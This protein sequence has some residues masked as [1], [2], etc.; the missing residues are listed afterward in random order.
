M[1]KIN[2]GRVVLGGLVAG[3]VMNAFWVANGLLLMEEW[4]A[5]MERS[6]QPV[7]GEGATALLHVLLPFVGGL[8]AVWFYAAARPRF[9]P[10]PKTAALI[11][12]ANWAVGYLVPGLAWGTTVAF[13]PRLLGIWIVWA[14]PGV[15]VATLAGAWL[16]KEA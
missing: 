16:Y 4:Q 1:G 10:G 2:W 9:G 12:F 6:G 11:G 8:I 7:E 5:V 13:P 14:L 3:I 15:V